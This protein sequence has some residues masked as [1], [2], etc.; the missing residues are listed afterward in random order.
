[1]YNDRQSDPYRG[2]LKSQPFSGIR[3]SVP[4]FDVYSGQ[5]RGSTVASQGDI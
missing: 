2:V 5:F 1:M 3:S 4:L